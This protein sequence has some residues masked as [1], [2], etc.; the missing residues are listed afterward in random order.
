MASGRL[1]RAQAALAVYS[2]PVWSAMLFAASVPEHVDWGSNVHNPCT[3]GV[4]FYTQTSTHTLIHAPVNISLSFGPVIFYTLFVCFFSLSSF[5]HYK[6]NTALA[7]HSECVRH[8]RF[9]AV[10]A[11]A[12]FTHNQ[13][14]CIRLWVKRN[15]KPNRVQKYFHIDGLFSLAYYR[16]NDMPLFIAASHKHSNGNRFGTASHAA[17][18]PCVRPTQSR[19]PSMF[20]GR[21]RPDAALPDCPESTSTDVLRCGAAGKQKESNRATQSRCVCKS[22]AKH[23]DNLTL[24]SR[25]LRAQWSHWFAHW[26]AP[27]SEPVRAQSHPPCTRREWCGNIPAHT[28]RSAGWNERQAQRNDARISYVMHRE[29]LRLESL[30]PRKREAAQHNCN[31]FTIPVGNACVHALWMIRH[32]YYLLSSDSAFASEIELAERVWGGAKRHD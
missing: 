21:N 2:T 26:T 28:L 6:T 4:L 29:V 25:K 31:K 12:T 1:E 17:D 30:F 13:S 18:R 5:F 16:F 20:D 3:I 24:M 10:F 27:N 8:Q 23:S 15:E 9:W 22:A 7:A 19:H 32:L 11:N 14:Y